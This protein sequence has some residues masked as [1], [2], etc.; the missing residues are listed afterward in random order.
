MDGESVE[1]GGSLTCRACLLTLPLLE[2]AHLVYVWGASDKVYNDNDVLSPS[3][4][5]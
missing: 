3:Y 5:L 1:R 2:E 4:I